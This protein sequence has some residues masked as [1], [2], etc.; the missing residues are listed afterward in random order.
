[1]PASLEQMIDALGKLINKRISR[2]FDRSFTISIKSTGLIWGGRIQAQDAN[3]SYDGFIR[4]TEVQTPLVWQSAPA[5]MLNY[6]AAS[7]GAT[8][9]ENLK[10]KDLTDLELSMAHVFFDDLTKDLNMVS[11]PKYGQEARFIDIRQNHLLDPPLMGYYRP[12]HFDFHCNDITLQLSLYLPQQV[13]EGQKFNPM[14]ANVDPAKLVS[15]AGDIS[16]DI[17]AK[18]IS[19]PQLQQLK[20]GDFL[21]LDNY[22]CALVLSEKIII[23]GELGEINHHWAIKITQLKNDR[24]QSELLSHKSQIRKNIENQTA[25]YNPIMVDHIIKHESFDIRVEVGQPNLSSNE[26]LNLSKG[27]IVEIKNHIKQPLD[28][29][30]GSA[31][32]GT[33]QIIKD[34]QSCGIIIKN[35]VQNKIA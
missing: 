4:M 6:L 25:S 33:G 10:K 1:M 3:T 35:L 13:G 30:L 7:L 12:I 22:H 2:L 11:Q 14:N 29:F 8:E 27:Q 32:L 34:K 21:P 5:L 18:S 28:F 16:V 19:T 23:Y 17:Y 20:A 26:L 9:I 31:H 24:E 15:L